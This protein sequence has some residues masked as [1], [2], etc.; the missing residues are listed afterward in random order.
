MSKFETI[1]R[2][3]DYNGKIWDLDV[4]TVPVF[5]AD[6]STVESGDIGQLFGVNSLEI[7][8]PGN[9]NT[10]KFFN[11]LFD[12]GTTPTIGLKQSVACQ[13]L[14]NGQAVFDGRLFIKNII[15]NQKFDTI[16]NC[17]VFNKLI[18]FKLVAG[19]LLLTDINWSEYNHVYDGPT[20]VNS[21][22]D[23]LFNGDIYYP[24]LDYGKNPN[25]DN[26]PFIDYGT[27]TTNG[28]INDQFGTA[29]QI[30]QF[31]PTIRL[32]AVIDKIFDTLGFR[33]ESAFM[34]SDYF[35]N[36][37]YLT[38]ND[39]I[40]W[41]FA[42]GSFTLAHR[43]SADGPFTIVYGNPPQKAI[44]PRATPNPGLLYN[45]TTERYTAPVSGLYTA[46]FNAP[47]IEAN[48]PIKNPT[49]GFT[50]YAY[51]YI[52][53]AAVASVSTNYS[54]VIPGVGPYITSLSGQWQV[55][56]AA[57]D[58]VEIFVDVDDNV[59]TGQFLPNGVGIDW[60]PTGV[61]GFR[62]QVVSQANPVG[63]NVN[64]SAIMQSGENA[65]EFMKGIIQKFNLIMYPDLNT[66]AFV[67]EPYNDW[68]QNGQVKDWTNIVDRGTRY[69]IEHPLFFSRP[70]RILFNDV[71]DTDYI[72]NELQIPAGKLTYGLYRYID[73]GD[74]AQ[75]DL[76]IGEYFASTPV[77]SLQ[78]IESPIPR[79]YELETST[80]AQKPYK[81][82]HRILHKYQ[83]ELSIQEAWY[84][85]VDYSG[86]PLGFVIYPGLI[87]TGNAIPDQFGRNN[88]PITYTNNEPDQIDLHY[89]SYLSPNLPVGN[90]LSY[91][92]GTQL[93]ANTAKN[94]FT[95]YWDLYI[96]TLYNQ[97]ARKLTCNV[98]ISPEM[99]AN[100]DLNDNI[101][102]DGH[103]Y[104]IDKI[105][106]ADF[107]EQKSTTVELIKLT[108]R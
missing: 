19:D 16:Y 59:A 32:K 15:T 40:S 43:N 63:A 54:P 97:D 104:R 69:K 87:P 5:Q 78:I 79:L 81:F 10:N 21:W 72:Q 84:F 46:S 31:K 1:I 68:I 4:S 103:Y 76:S 27:T 89:G 23:N 50:A 102:I 83:K 44:F 47:L 14:V 20:I 108:K 101:F 60:G 93:Q 95:E 94:A 48:V 73:D 88:W 90:N 39:D 100:I 77:N 57:G 26:P 65:L 38:T 8:I 30:T 33:Y 56:L 75:G 58:Y 37:Y 3:I 49:D 67:I 51:L 36:L 98:I 13:V 66:N 91:A 53:G 92:T 62:M 42:S 22:S 2:V 41:G 17:E 7:P 96:D 6:L 55:E 35:K 82:K 99:L 64:L 85:K 28:Y 9:K 24:L 12:L 105:E 107:I 71:Q 52:N 25:L 61:G 18:D 86:L 106:Q 80:G 70:K 34:D 29:V 11:H 45:T 74:V